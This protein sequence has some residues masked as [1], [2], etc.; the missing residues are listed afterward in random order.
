MPAGRPS[1]YR[2]EYCD[3]VISLG[4][5]GKSFAQMAAACGVSKQTMTAWINAHEE[6]LTAMELAR[7]LSQCWWENIGQENIVSMPGSTLNSGVYSR[8][9]AARFPD[10]WR[11]NK[12]VEVTGAGG[13]PI[14]SESTV[15]LTAEEAYKR[16]LNGG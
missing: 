1:D 13:G 15:V 7:T 5:D 11:E 6:F 2:P 12:G 4:N 16:M 14:K 8:S 9:M 3:L 10:D